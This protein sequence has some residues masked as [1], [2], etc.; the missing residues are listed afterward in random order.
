[1]S[2]IL[3][4]EDDSFKSEALVAIITNVI[5]RPEITC[6]TNVATA[7]LNVNMHVFDLIIVDMAL[8]SHSLISGGGSPVSLLNGGLEILLE[9]NS[10]DRKD[11][12]IIVTQYPEIEIGGKFFPVRKSAAAIREHFECDVVECLE[13]SEESDDWKLKL[14]KLLENYENT[15]P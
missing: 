7:I 2:R 14:I 13:Y 1:M 3:V 12:C 11:H 10:L 4:V 9:L 15:T 6:S 8:P 5:R